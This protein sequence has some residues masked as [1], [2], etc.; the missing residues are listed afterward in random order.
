MSRRPANA[1]VLRGWID[2]WAPA[3]D[4]AAE[5]IG[6]LLEATPGFD[7]SAADVAAKAR[8]AREARTDELLAIG[9]ESAA[10]DDGR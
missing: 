5:G 6:S 7:R 2:R 1:E 10:T 9:P 8:A 4:E 3:A